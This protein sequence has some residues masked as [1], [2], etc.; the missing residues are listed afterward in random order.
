M[1]EDLVNHIWDR[2]AAHNKQYVVGIS[3]FGGS[4]K[5]TVAHKLSALVQPSAVI[6]VDNFY[7]LSKDVADS[8]WNCFDREQFRSA[9]VSSP[10][11]VVFAEG[12]GIFHEDTVSLFD[13]RV[14]VDVDIETATE[15]GM[16]RDREE[17]EI[18]N[19]RK[20]LQVWKENELRFLEAHHPIE[21]VD[22]LLNN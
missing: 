1:L 18:N 2:V 21:K 15:R 16:K 6:G 4:G 13:L 10:S 11:P 12:V 20:W 14:W 8:D 3:G 9:I 17:Q 5:S 22:F 7:V 19:D